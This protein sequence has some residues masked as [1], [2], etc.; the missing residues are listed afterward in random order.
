MNDGPA[1]S[2]ILTELRK[3]PRT[4]AEIMASVGISRNAVGMAVR[5][6]KRLGY[7]VRNVRKPGGLTLAL[8]ALMHDADNPAPRACSWAGCETRLA[9]SN[10]TAYCRVHQADVAYYVYLEALNEVLDELLGAENEQL[11]IAAV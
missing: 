11:T 7:D 9:P 2:A 6:L 5:R 3:G 10:K 4:T 8:Y 1:S